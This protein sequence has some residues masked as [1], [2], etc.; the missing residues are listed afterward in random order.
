MLIVEIIQGMLLGL[1]LLVALGPKDAFVIKNSIAKNNA[2]LLIL[3]C[4][5]SDVFLISVG[6]VGLGHL[7][8]SNPWFMTIAM[9]TSIAYLLYFGVKAFI[10]FCTGSSQ[11]KIPDHAIEISR[12]RIVK[13]ALFHS[14]LTP[15]AWLDTVLIIG[16]IGATK[17]GMAQFGFAAGAMMASLCWFIFLTIGSQLAAPI[18]KNR[19]TWQ[20]LDMLVALSM[21]VLSIKLIQDYPWH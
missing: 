15:Y 19:R 2:L 1:G 16:S 7:I 17:I 21:F 9:L 12:S 11:E 4:T 18:F 5:L 14:L 13:G 6:M 3:I 10:S 8:T 20:A